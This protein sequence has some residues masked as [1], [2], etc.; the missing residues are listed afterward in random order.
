MSPRT[1]YTIV[2][3]IGFFLGVTI[4]LVA[5]LVIPFI[6]EALPALAELFTRY[7]HII[8]ALLSGFVGSIVA[9]ILAYL[10]ATRSEF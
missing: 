5:A 9:V 6:I 10:W 8:G 4:Y 3:L 7:Q 2:A 1:A